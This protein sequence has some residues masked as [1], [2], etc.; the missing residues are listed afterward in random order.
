VSPPSIT[1]NATPKPAP[2]GLKPTQSYD[3]ALAMT[4]SAGGVDT[5][6]PLQR[7]TPIP[8]DQEPLLVELGVLQSGGKVLFAVEPGTVVNG[9][10]TCTPGPIDCEILSLGQDQTE[11]ISSRDSSANALFAITGISAV[12]HSSVGDANRARESKSAA[13]QAVLDSTSG[14][15]AL[16]L[17]KYEPSV[18]SV[19]DLRDLGVN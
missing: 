6:D 5:T 12:T 11:S 13:G 18:G 7:L 16:S 2:T 4:N 9:P 8:S 19:V 14:L 3:V 17:F 10:G 1:G 15:A